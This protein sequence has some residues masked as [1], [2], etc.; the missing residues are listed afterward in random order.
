MGLDVTAYSAYQN[1]ADAVEY[2][3]MGGCIEFH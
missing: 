1:F 3:S 2:A